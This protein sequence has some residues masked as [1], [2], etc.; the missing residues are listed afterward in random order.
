MGER[1]VFLLEQ[2]DIHIVKN[3]LGL[4]P[5]TNKKIYSKT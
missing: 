3:E 5:Y 4:L 2:L 1:L